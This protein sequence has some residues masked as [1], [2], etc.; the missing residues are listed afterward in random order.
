[1]IRKSV[2]A[3]IIC[4]ALS[5]SVHA[6]PIELSFWSLLGGGDGQIMNELVARFNEE[7]EDITVTHTILDWGDPYYSKLI[8]STVGGSP[9]SVGIMH[10]SR[11][12]S[13]MSQQLIEPFTEKDLERLGLTDRDFMPNIWERGL[14]EGKPHAIPLD[15]HPYAL[16]MNVRMFEQSGLPLESPRNQ[17]ELLSAARLL[18]RDV[19]GDGTPDI[20]GFTGFGSREWLGYLYQFGGQIMDEN[21]QAAFDTDAGREALNVQLDVI[22]QIGGAPFGWFGNETAAMQLLGPWEIGNFTRIGLDFKTDVV[23]QVG[24]EQGTWAGSHMLV[25]PVGIRENRPDEFEAALTFISWLSL[26]TIDWSAG[27]GHVPARID[28][29]TVD[30]FLQLE[31]QQAF[32]NSLP[33]A[34]FWP[35]HRLEG[36]LHNGGI[37]AYLTN[38]MPLNEAITNM[39][40]AFRRVMEESGN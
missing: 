22:N 25:I 2:L 26:H 27:A 35:D 36:E 15:I 9:P 31:P 32:A 8:T 38:Q 17:A 40:D 33:F 28:R 39:V 7:H 10:A 30:S 1:M 3:L 20:A 29:L 11:I 23:P 6:A 12:Y 37:W 19:N 21:R 14:Y 24:P 4:I 13:F 5:L 18:T 34:Q 16:Y